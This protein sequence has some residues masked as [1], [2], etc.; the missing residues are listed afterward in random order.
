[1][2]AGVL[3]DPLLQA[4]LFA[5]SVF[6]VIGSVTLA[7]LIRTLQRERGRPLHVLATI[8]GTIALGMLVI[9]ALGIDPGLGIVLGLIAGLGA[10]L[11]WL[12]GALVARARPVWVDILVILATLAYLASYAVTA[13][14][15]GS[16]PGVFSGITIPR[17]DTAP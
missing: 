16:G 13:E 15:A 4:I 5:A 11:F 14:G 7:G 2:M 17:P 6:A 10:G 8:L 3:A 9:L 12:V 1:M